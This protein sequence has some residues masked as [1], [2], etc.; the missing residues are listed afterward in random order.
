MQQK[1][2]KWAS[3]IVIII[4]IIKVILP[5]TRNDS[6]IE[7][8]SE[9]LPL[10][11]QIAEHIIQTSIQITMV[12]QVFEKVDTQTRGSEQNEIWG[13]VDKWTT[14]LGTLVSHQGDILLISHDHWSLFTSSTAPDKVIFRD[15]QGST[16]LEMDGANL[17]PL[18][19]FHDS[20]T[21]ILRV[22][23]ELVAKTSVRADMGSFE[24]TSPGDIVHVVHRMSGQENQLAIAA[25]EIVGEEMFNGVPMLSLRCLNGCS[26]EPGDSG[27][28]IW[29]NGR[30]AGN[31]WMT[32]RETRQY[33]WQLNPS[34]DNQTA[35]SLAA[36]L[37]IE[38]IDLV[39]TLLQ[40]ESPPNLE[41]GSRS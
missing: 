27:G 13:K 38:L 28:G 39:G 7:N 33:W 5:T 35:F 17:L 8:Q 40:V 4:T 22:P 37:T 36:G 30:L 31:M 18:I 3:L 10:D 29:V 19:L 11:P 1:I 32:V 21:F 6:L 12:E 23:E 26:I 15:A 16:L 2:W 9:S 34:D 25:A 14:G 24:S 41:T 20:G